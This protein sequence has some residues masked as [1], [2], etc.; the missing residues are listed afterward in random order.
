MAY[1]KLS[2]ETK[3]RKNPMRPKHSKG[4]PFGKQFKYSLLHGFLKEDWHEFAR[5]AFYQAFSPK[6]SFKSSSTVPI[7][8]IPKFSTNTFVTLGERNPGSVG[9]R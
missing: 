5:H 9:P 7:P 4:A 3:F 1:F 2:Y 6:N 8:A